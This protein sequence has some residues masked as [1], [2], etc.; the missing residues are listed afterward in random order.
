MPAVSEGLEAGPFDATFQ[1]AIGG[2]P[3][4]TVIEFA[5]RRYSSLVDDNMDEPR[6][7]E[8]WSDATDL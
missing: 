5:G 4:G 6:G 1:R 8:K 2:Y 7:S 3:E